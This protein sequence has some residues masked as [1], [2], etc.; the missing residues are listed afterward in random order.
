MKYTRRLPTAGDKG[1]QFSKESGIVFCDTIREFRR[2]PL[3][4]IKKNILAYLPRLN[5][6]LLHNT[7]AK[8][9][10]FFHGSTV[11]SGP[12]PSLLY[13]DTPHSAGLLW[14]SDQPVAET[15]TRQHTIADYY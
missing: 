6:A 14:T 7:D 5:N 3:R 4:Q 13:S 12:A 10:G 9:Y 15:S 11:P 8:K 1:S 2:L